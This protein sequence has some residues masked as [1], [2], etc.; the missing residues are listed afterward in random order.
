VW[1]KWK[2]RVRPAVRPHA[3]FTFRARYIQML[4]ISWYCCGLVCSLSSFFSQSLCHL[5][6]LSISDINKVQASL[7]KPLEKVRTSENVLFL[8]KDPYSEGVNLK[9]GLTRK[10]D[11]HFHQ[12]S[13]LLCLTGLC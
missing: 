11:K 7:N 1:E 10:K 3:E 9:L 8:Q 12:Q 13:C 2:V 4:H 6:V 5:P